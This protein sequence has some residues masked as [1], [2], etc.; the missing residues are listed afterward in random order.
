MLHT[1]T[2]NVAYEVISCLI[3]VV[4]ADSTS[5]SQ[6]MSFNQKSLLNSQGGDSGQKVQCKGVLTDIIKWLTMTNQQATLKD[7]EFSMLD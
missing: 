1:S 4:P 7:V 2:K 5:S 6:P 3:T